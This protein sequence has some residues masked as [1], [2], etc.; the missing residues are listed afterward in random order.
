MTQKHKKPA[1][2]HHLHLHISM[3]FAVATMFVTV[4]K[5]SSELIK[6]AYAMPVHYE[7]I[8]HLQLR[9]A[10]TLHSHAITTMARR[11]AITG[12]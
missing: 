6:T 2:V 3:L 5:S 12:A 7:G 9:E 1:K 8:H 4:A 10:E 11:T